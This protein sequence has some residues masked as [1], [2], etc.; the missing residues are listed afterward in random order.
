[1]GQVGKHPKGLPHMS[2]PSTA[3]PLAPGLA[4]PTKQGPLLGA[5][6]HFHQ[7]PPCL[8]WAGCTR[9]P[10]DLPSCQCGP[11]RTVSKITVT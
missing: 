3:L 8:K 4:V 10:L 1:M 7:E 11:G 2:A 6:R 9:E 5:E